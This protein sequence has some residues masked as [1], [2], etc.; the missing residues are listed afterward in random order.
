MDELMKK[1]EMRR[2]PEEPL[3]QRGHL[4]PRTED[5]DAT[6]GTSRKGKFLDFLFQTYPFG[7]QR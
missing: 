1:K 3:R 6:L 5:T 4:S 7:L 2:A